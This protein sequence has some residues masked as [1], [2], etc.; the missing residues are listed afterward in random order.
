MTLHTSYLSFLDKSDSPREIHIWE[1]PQKFY[2][3]LESNIAK[4]LITQAAERMG[5][6]IQ[7]ASILKVHVSTVYK[8]RAGKRF[9]PL[10]FILKLCDFA[11][12]EVTIE[13]MEPYIIG[14]K[15]R[16][17]ARPVRNPHLPIQETSALFAL[18]GHLMGDGGHSDMAYYHNTCVSLTDEFLN[19]LHEVFGEVPVQIAVDKRPKKSI[20]A[21]F[22]VRFAM[23][24]VRLL[25]HLYLT[26]FRTFTGRV[27][28][29]L[30]D[31]PREFTAAYLRA[32]GDDE[33]SVHEDQLDLVS[34]NEK[35]MQDI[36][37]LVQAKFP[38]LAEF[39]AFGERNRELYANMYIIRFRTGAFA[40]YR[41]LIGFNH[42]EKKQELDRILT[43]RKRGWTHRRPGITRRMILESLK[44]KPT[45]IKEL[46]NTLEVNVKAIRYHF[47][48]LAKLGAVIQT[49]KTGRSMTF[50]LTETGRK[51]LELPPIGL[52]FLEHNWGLRTRLA[53]LKALA[54]TDEGLTL[55]KLTRQLGFQYHTIWL[56]L[57]TRRRQGQKSKKLG[58]ME[59]D[60]V[61]RSRKRGKDPY[62]YSLTDEGRRVVEELEILFP[63]L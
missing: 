4:Q 46:A 50:A 34:A 12:N 32:Y 45:T 2:V 57:I 15:S 55:G 36:Y 54:C 25:R 37:A 62:V 29:R 53:I 5:G 6:I 31:L 30:F 3:Q 9:I 58:L 41:K 13:Q 27:P 22:V 7:L 26:D 18:M 56:H 60:L 49:G 63:D 39:V 52:E 24:I 19:L 33:G 40:F 47:K 8:Y 10:A 48:V 1:F 23:T 28:Y 21:V 17:N 20:K 35:L 14:Y 44:S 38:E 16:K 43:R 59:L 51:F 61:R 42:P 11:G